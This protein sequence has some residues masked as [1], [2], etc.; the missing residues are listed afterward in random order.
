MRMYII[1]IFTK[2]NK[3]DQTREDDMAGT[4]ITYGG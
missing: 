4:C 3:C 1:F 2:Y